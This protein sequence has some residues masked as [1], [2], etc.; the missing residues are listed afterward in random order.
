[1]AIRA[2]SCL[3]DIKELAIDK[4]GGRENQVALAPSRCGVRQLRRDAQDERD[5][6]VELS[7]T[8]KLTETMAK[9][10]VLQELLRS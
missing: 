6:N 3:L 1:M 8:K 5:N 9:L 4:S 2:E 7:S 10:T